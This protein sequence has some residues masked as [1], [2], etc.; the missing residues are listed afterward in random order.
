[1]IKYIVKVYEDGTVEWYLNGKRHR[2]D[3]PAVEWSDK[4]II[5][6]VAA[7]WTRIGVNGVNN[8]C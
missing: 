4:D 2:A 7:N 8:G 5:K 6:A 3:G 1:M